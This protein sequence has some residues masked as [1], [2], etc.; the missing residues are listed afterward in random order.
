MTQYSFFAT[1]VGWSPE[2]V[3]AS[4]GLCD[5]IDAGREISRRTFLSYVDRDSMRDIEAALG[6]A[7]HPRQG[8][9]MAGDHH[10]HYY[11]SR[12]H[13]APCAYF[14]HSAIEHVVIL[15]RTEV[16]GFGIS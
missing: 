12:L 8:L 13:G 10:V 9:T 2:D 14:V 6:Y 16:R 3:D 11:R 1:C 15:T 5:M 4:G 7:A